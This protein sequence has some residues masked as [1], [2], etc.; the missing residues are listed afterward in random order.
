MNTDNYKRYA[1]SFLS[2]L[3]IPE[4][5]LVAAKYQS[6]PGWDSMGHIRL[7]FAIE[8]EFNIKFTTEEIV[9][10]KTFDDGISILK[11]AHNIDI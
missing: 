6:T 9:S 8:T 4:K 3:D 7:I 5:E 11:T 10:F 2:V 1:E